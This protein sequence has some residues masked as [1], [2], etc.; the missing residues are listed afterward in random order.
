MSKFK[1]VMG[2]KARPCLITQMCDSEDLIT[3]DSRQEYSQVA[4]QTRDNNQ[5]G[6]PPLALPSRLW[7][8]PEPGISAV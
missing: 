3:S 4:T 6:S 5:Y 7:T 1:D 8:C 2:Y